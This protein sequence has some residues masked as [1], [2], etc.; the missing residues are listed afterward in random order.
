MWDDKRHSA[1]DPASL[2]GPR[3]FST[4]CPGGS[5]RNGAAPGSILRAVGLFLART[6]WVTFADDDVWWE[7]RYLD[8]VERRLG[9]TNWLS[10]HRT[11]YSPFTGARIGVDRFES[12]GDAP[13]RKVPYEMCD[14]NT[15]IFRREFGTAAARLFRETRAYNDD[16]LMYAFLKERAGPRSAIPDALVNQTC[17]ERLAG[18]FQKFCDPQ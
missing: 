9:T 5:G 8:E 13:S 3:R 11:I 12:V 6:P 14:G 4:V 7:G 16:R 10:V 2:D 15:M 1:I 18:F 17:P